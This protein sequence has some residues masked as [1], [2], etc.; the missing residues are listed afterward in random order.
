MGW[1]PWKRSTEVSQPWIM[2]SSAQVLKEYA[3]SDRAFAD[4]YGTSR[5]FSSIQ[6]KS[7]HPMDRYWSRNWVRYILARKEA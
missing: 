3:D 4:L 6:F 2:R 1:F 7:M 5:F